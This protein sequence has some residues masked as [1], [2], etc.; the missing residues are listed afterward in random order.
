MIYTILYHDHLKKI[1]LEEI[2]A[3]MS[4]GKNE[5]GSLVFRAE[6]PPSSHPP[7]SLH[8][9]SSLVLTTAT[10]STIALSQTFEDLLSTSRHPRCSKI[11]RTPIWQPLDLGD[12]CS[13]TF[14]LIRGSWSHRQ[15]PT[16]ESEDDHSSSSSLFHIRKDPSKDVK[17]WVMNNREIS[18]TFGPDKVER[19]LTTHYLDLVCRA[20]QIA[21]DGYELFAERQLVTIFSTPNSCGEFDNIGALMS[22][23]EELMCFL[24]ILKPVDENGNKVMVPTRT[25]VASYEDAAINI[26]L[27]SDASCLRV[28]HQ[29][30][31]VQIIDHDIAL[32]FQPMFMLGI[33]IGTSSLSFF[34]GIEMWK[35]ETILKFCSI[36]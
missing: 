5:N 3:L 18:Y 12:F 23:D 20:Y 24:Q 32:L 31:D 34:E 7:S 26:S 22:V 13:E 21:A 8:A 9:Q 36:G 16:K 6:P 25:F 33:T 27:E 29:T 17:G 1:T 10:P 11:Y 2:W 19:V 14:S 15:S 28:A 4:V 30:K 35:E